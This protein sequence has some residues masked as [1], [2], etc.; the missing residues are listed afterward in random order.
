VQ[1]LRACVP[2]R[3]ALDAI[4][5]AAADVAQLIPELAE[6]PER[7]AVAPPVEPAGA[8]R[9]RP[10]APPRAADPTPADRELAGAAMLAPEQAR[11]RLFD[12]VTSFFKHASAARPLVLVL[13]DLHWADKPSL[14]LLQFLAREMR[15]AH[16]LVLGTYRDVALGRQHP[17]AE[18]LGE[19]ARQPVCHRVAL[20]GLAEADVARFIELTTGSAPGTKVATAVYEMTEGNPF[21]V[22]E[23]VRLLA[24]EGRLQ[25]PAEATA[26]T[27]TLP[28]GVR[29][30][31]GR[32]LNGLSE[33]C[34]RVLALASVIGRE[35]RVNVLQQVADVP[36]ERVLETLEEAVAARIVSAPRSPAEPYAFS[37]TLVRET[38]YE[39]LT[40]PARVR[41]HRRVGEV[42]ER[43]HG[44][45][46]TAHLAELAHHFFDAAPGGDAAKA[47]DYAR[48][49][50]ARALQ[51]LAYE[52]AASHYQRA[53]QGSELLPV[54]DDADRCELLLGLGDAQSRAGERADARA[55]FQRAAEI[56]R[57]RGRS[58]LLARA[59][60]GFGGRGEFGAG[61]DEAVRV[62]LEEALA[63]LGEDEDALRARLLS[64]MTGTEPYSTSMTTR[65]RLSRQAVELAE[66]AADPATLMAAWGARYWALLGPDRVEERA[67]V[68]A[69]LLRL[70]EKTGDKNCAFLGHEVRLGVL[71]ALGDIAGADREIEIMAGLVRELRQP[72]EHWFV[73][74]CR[75]SRAIADGRFAEGERLLHEGL[76]IGQRAQHPTALDAFA[77]QMLWLRGEQGTLHESENLEQTFRMLDERLPSA[78][79]ILRA[80]LANLLGDMGRFEEARATLDE[81]AAHDFA[82]IP[83]DEHWLVTMSMLAEVSA[84]LGDARRAALV[85]ELLRP[86]ADRN[87]VHDLIRAYRGSV[88]FSLGILA[89]TMG[90]VT[91]AARHFEDALAMNAKMGTRPYLVRTQI[92]YTRLLLERGRRQ[93][94]A[95]ARALVAEAVAGAREME[96]KRNLALGLEM[97]ERIEGAAG[98]RRRTRA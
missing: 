80:G 45:D 9:A 28:Q 19:L 17:L 35:F 4:G 82:D 84:D 88:A 22:G 69:E 13:D 6:L 98:A 26:L 43:V 86:F 20:R 27:I 62:L 77:G 60:L 75:A 56:A 36:A 15:D 8:R 51:L 92:E 78:R 59:A 94:L 65:D 31:I 85:Y 46:P 42:L 87:A 61:P 48:R 89:R 55:T 71:L 16:V 95:K 50:A 68:G 44:S 52:E 66:R 72:I 30:A 91:D 7:R 70:A 73:T 25:R 11:F 38:L 23:I 90:R 41:L 47:V 83:R 53:L 12:A 74:W 63:A 79:G 64:R 57:R 5:P 18:A 3:A 96:M 33:E 76:A 14:L 1:I 97:Q 49:A 2:D 24:G 93:D 32:R 40:V 21:F 34:N 10:A 29:E 67:V 58:D 39:E 81:L 37:H 54:A